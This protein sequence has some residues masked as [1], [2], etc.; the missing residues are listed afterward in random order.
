MSCKLL[1]LAIHEP[2]MISFVA[3]M[4]VYLSVQF[5]MENDTSSCLVLQARSKR[6]DDEEGER[7]V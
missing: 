7:L 6:D 5:C 1:S 2:Y 4:V 3:V